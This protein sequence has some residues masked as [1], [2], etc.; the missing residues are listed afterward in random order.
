MVEQHI[1]TNI[2]DYLVLDRR[3]LLDHTFEGKFFRKIFQVWGA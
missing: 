1:Q 3:E 2:I